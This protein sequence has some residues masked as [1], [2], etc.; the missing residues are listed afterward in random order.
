MPTTG[1]ETIQRMQKP[2]IPAL[3]RV[4]SIL[5][6]IRLPNL[7]IIILTQVFIRFCILQPFLYRDHPEAISP[8]V[9]FLLLIIATI[10]ITTAGYVINDYYD[11]KIDR[12]NK[13]DRQV[14][15]R[16]ISYRGAIK[17]H[18]LL[19]VIAVL[20]GFILAFRVR[21]LSFGFIFLFISGLLWLYSARYKRIVFWGNFLV[22]MLSATVILIVWL[23]DFYFLLLSPELFD[24]VMPGH[25]WVN[26]L[27]IAYAVFAFLVSLFR[28]IIKDMEDQ[29]GDKSMGCRTLPVVAG[30]RVTRLI[31]M[32]II[33]LTV[34][35]LGFIQMAV[36][37]L[38]QYYLFWYLLVLVQFP[39]II[40]LY[41]L[42]TAKVKS[43]FHVMSMISK[44]V[45]LTGILSMLFLM[46]L[47]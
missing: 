12:I 40:L 46:F 41:K 33:V 14:V 8:L 16:L 7:L 11:V 35:L 32:L 42:F 4:K 31:V 30:N 10:L 38:N 19:N 39:M 2:H 18:I 29:D 37:A 34:F 28:E 6:F 26:Q 45:M 3:E 17:L 23:F 1:R 21:V 44:L 5:Q 9:D 25:A 20:I 47:K 27:I 24:L 13:P 43:D 36:F 22:A 15:S